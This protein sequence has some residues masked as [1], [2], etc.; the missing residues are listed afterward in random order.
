MNLQT[1]LLK[2]TAAF[3]AVS[4]MINAKLAKWAFAKSNDGPWASLMMLMPSRL[5]PD[6]NPSPPKAHGGKGVGGLRKLAGTA[7]T[8]H[9]YAQPPSHR[10]W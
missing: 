1:S 7:Q 9:G 10:S 8:R 2:T 3:Q 5:E 6:W 4:H